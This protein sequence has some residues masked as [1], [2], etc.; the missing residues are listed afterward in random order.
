MGCQTRYNGLISV[1]LGKHLSLRRVL[2]P[3]SRLTA[4]AAGLAPGLISRQ[5]IESDDWIQ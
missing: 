2:Q 1:F 4:L 3:V 5:M